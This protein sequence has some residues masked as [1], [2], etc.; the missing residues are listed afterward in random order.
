MQVLNLTRLPHASKII[1]F[2]DRLLAK[3]RSAAAGENAE[4]L[5]LLPNGPAD[6]ERPSCGLVAANR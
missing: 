6:E 2:S 4:T 5:L 1:Y 3:K